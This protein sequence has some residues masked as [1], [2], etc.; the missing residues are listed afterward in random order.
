MLLALAIIGAAIYYFVTGGALLQ[1][2]TTAQSA[3][4]ASLPTV[5]IQPADIA[6]SATSAGGNLALVEERSVPL[7]V[8][9]IVKEIAAAVGD[10]VQAG[11]VLL[12]L[13]TTE[14]ERA[15]AQAELSVESAQITLADLAEE[16]TVAELAQAEAALIEAQENLADV[17]AGPSAAEIAAAQ[18]SLA[19]A[20]SS[21][22]ELVAGPSEDELT[23]LSASLRKAEITL[24]DAQRAYDQIAWQG[25]ASAGSQA[26]ELQSATIDY[27]STLAAYQESTA[28]ASNSSRQS[29]VSS[30]QNAQASL[31][32][33]LSSPSTAEIATAEAQVAEAEAALSDLQ[34]GPTANDLRSAE[35]TMEKA[36]IDLESAQR[37]LDAAVLAA[38]VSG[39]VTAINATMGTRSSADS[40]AVTLTDPTQ[41]E[42]VINVAEADIPNVSEGQE[43]TVEVDAFPGKS[44]TGVVEAVSPVNDSSASSV[45]YPV[46]IRLTS[47]D[48]TGVLPGMN[49]VATLVSQVE[50]P[51]NSWLVPTNAVQSA[52]GAATV[53]VL[54]DGLPVQITVTPGTIQG[55]YTMVQSADLEAGDEVVGTL[56]SSG[57]ESNFFGGPAGG[58]MGVPLGGAPRN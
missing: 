52:N 3:A 28:A 41:L 37:D 14:L 17:K 26:I 6:E 38:P 20:N 33:L 57:D 16:P 53:T 11:D 55:E 51:E 34:S 50:I 44:Y 58:G 29:A 19:A 45:S 8:G 25:S 36:L 46:T 47:E 30:I 22:T 15:L 27:E 49:A 56:A 24:A 21:Y 48:L 2:S 35:I 1:P 42:L 31:D 12:R 9:G 32:T 18:S 4:T 7:A 23:Q 13:D 54:R 39:V 10:Q 5:V 43:A 40:A